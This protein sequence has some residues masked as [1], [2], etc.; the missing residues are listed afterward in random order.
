MMANLYQRGATTNYHLA[1]LLQRGATIEH[2]LITQQYN[3]VL[4]EWSLIFQGL[5]YCHNFPVIL[6]FSPHEIVF[7]V[8]L[9]LR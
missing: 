2:P 6:D 4:D 7:P 5:I 1:N 9:L 3:T 8:N